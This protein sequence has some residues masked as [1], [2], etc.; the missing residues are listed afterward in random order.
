MTKGDLPLSVVAPQED[1]PWREFI[2]TFVS[3]EKG[4]ESRFNTILERL[5]MLKGHQELCPE[6]APR[7]IEPEELEETPKVPEG[8]SEPV[9]TV[10]R[11]TLDP[12]RASKQ[13]LH[14]QG[15]FPMV[16]MTQNLHD[17]NGLPKF[18]HIPGSGDPGIQMATIYPDPESEESASSL[19][20]IPS[21]LKEKWVNC[22]KPQM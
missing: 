7:P 10:P 22:Q 20:Q 12:T 15:T 18:V 14:D 8:P 13:M 3:F 6:E 1:V 9:S 2:Q 19:A 17:N 11:R 5:D 4:L 21:H 16:T